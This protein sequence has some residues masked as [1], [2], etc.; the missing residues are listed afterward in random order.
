[1]SG[2]ATLN[3]RN[4]PEDVVVRLKARAA[5][6]GDSLNEEV[7]RTLSD[8]A[9]R[10]TVEDVLDS[11]DRIQATMKRRPTTSDEIVEGIHRAREER[12]EQILR[13]ALRPRDDA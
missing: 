1:M 5:R 6:K 7:V 12:T 3:I 11:I 8:A 13:A 10:R 2:M 9:A 4:V